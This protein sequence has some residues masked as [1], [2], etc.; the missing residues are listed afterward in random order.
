MLENIHIVVLKGGPGSEREVSL[1]S[2]SGVA[3]ALRN[4][5]AKEVSE[6]DVKGDDLVI[7]EGVDI[8]FNVIHGTFGEDGQIQKILEAKGVRY[9]GARSA[10]SRLAFDKIA[11]KVRFLERGVPTPG[12]ETLDLSL[13]QRPQL[14]LPLVIKP[15][16]EGSSVG[17]FIVRSE[18]EL[19]KA[20]KD[21]LRFGPRS[22]VEEYIEGKE[23]TVAVLGG[24]AL[25]IV[26]I[27]PRDG[28]YDI[29]NKYPWMN[30]AGGTDYF[31]P[32]E[33]SA[34][35]TER[36]K[37]AALAA[38]RALGVEVYSRVDVLLR[39]RDEA[40]FVLE[41]NTLPGMTESS[42]LPKAALA[43]GIG[44]GELC[45]RIIDLSWDLE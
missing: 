1:R 20:L 34:E 18:D 23:L 41:V 38:H 33:L 11:S 4:A 25:P 32:A 15:P 19:D 27:S 14:D 43:A 6:L 7:P 31:C 24:E 8:C 9:T 45:S 36:V 12:G 10:S 39:D 37:E 13:G 29:N 26:H 44:Y 40:P 17:V 22:M 2:A 35:V 16:C 5:G 3:D 30:Q 21:S 28:F 42:L